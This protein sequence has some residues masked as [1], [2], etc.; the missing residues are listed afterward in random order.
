LFY[1]RCDSRANI[2]LITAPIIRVEHGY[3]ERFRQGFQLSKY[4]IVS[5]PERKRRYLAGIVVYSEPKPP[6]IVFFARKTPHFIK[7]RFSDFLVQDNFGSCIAGLY[8]FYVV[9]VDAAYRFFRFFK[10]S[11]TFCFDIP[12]TLAISRMPQAFAV[13]LTI[14]L[15]MPGFQPLQAYSSMKLLPGHS[16]LL[17]IYRCMPF[18]PLPFLDMFVPSQA[19]HFTAVISVFIRSPFFLPFYHVSLL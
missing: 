15:S 13:I 16:L 19:G 17:H 8:A 18:A 5:P 14:S 4:N 6:R 11:Q 3:T 2:A 1:P 12:R 9:A 10:V 7:L